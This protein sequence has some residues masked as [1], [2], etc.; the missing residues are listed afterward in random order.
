MTENYDIVYILNRNGCDV[1]AV[2]CAPGTYL[3]N[4]ELESCNRCPLGTYQRLE[5]QTECI[6]CPEDSTTLTDSANHPIQCSER[7][8]V[9][10]VNPSGLTLK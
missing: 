10:G 1:F 6:P 8:S 3:P 5:G 4:P 2:P 9:I 7:I